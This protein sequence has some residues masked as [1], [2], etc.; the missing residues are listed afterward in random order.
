MSAGSSSFSGKLHA[1]VIGVS[2]YPY[3]PNLTTQGPAMS[4][5]LFA[6]W[7]RTEFRNPDLQLGSLRV[8]LSPTDGERQA[9]IDA[10][11]QLDG[12]A[13]RECVAR[14]LPLW[15]DRCN[16]SRDDAALLYV[17]GH[18][19]SMVAAGGFL[20]L[21]DFG[22]PG[23][24][25]AGALHIDAL[26]DRMEIRKA[27]ANFFFVDTCQETIEE[28]EDVEDPDAL[29]GIDLWR[30]GRRWRTFYRAVYGAAPEEQAWTLPEDEVMKS[31]TVFSKALLQALHTAADFDEGGGW[32]FCVTVERLIAETARNIELEGTE[33]KARYGKEITGS[34]QASGLGGNRP[35]HFPAQVPVD[36]AIALDPEGAAAIAKAKLYHYLLAPKGG[37][38]A[39]AKP[40]KVLYGD[41]PMAEQP[42]RLK[43]DSGKYE[44]Q[45]CSEPPG[46]FDLLDGHVVL[47]AAAY[48]KVPID[49]VR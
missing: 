35:F 23:T 39:R 31:G 44:L 19:T 45:V 26:R 28:Q 27:H 15:A 21:E 3:R 17:A 49:Y 24:V 11:G 4:A 14:E 32:G 7:L 36:L 12:P 8:L 30:G 40:R 47:P 13:T 10:A 20:L 42:A 6:Q 1:V 37:Q 2:N 5:A 46:D 9:A 43:V 38:A 34:S 33:L 16:Q 25:L 29:K 18:G 41:V 48:W 22:G